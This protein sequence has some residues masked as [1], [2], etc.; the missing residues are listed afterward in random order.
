MNGL[1]KKISDAVRGRIHSARFAAAHPFLRRGMPSATNGMALVVSLTDNV[2]QVKTEGMLAKALQIRG[3]KPVILT[4]RTSKQAQ[5]YFRAFGFADFVFLDDL[6]NEA[7]FDQA[8]ANAIQS[9]ATTFRSFLDVM[10]RGVRIG[11]HVLSTVVRRLRGGSGTFD[12][13]AVKRLIAGL[14]PLSLRTVGATDLLFSRLKPDV[15]CFLEKGYTPYGEIFDA[16]INRNIPCIQYVHSQRSNA[17]VLK[18]YGPQNRTLHPFS[19]SRETWKRVLA[20]P[21]TDDEQKTF[22]AELEKSYAEGTWFNRKF[23][24]EGKKMKSPQEVQVQLKLDPAKKTA[25]IFSHVL[26]DA[27]FFFGSTLFADY[28]EWLVE[29]VR[30]ACANDRV[31]WIIKLHPDYVWKMKMMGDHGD[32]RDI[33]ALQT[34]IGTLPSHVQVVAPDTDISTYSFFAVT[35]YAITVRGTIGIEAPCFGIPVFTAGTGRYSGLGFTEDSATREE[36]LDKM[37]RIQ[38]FPKLSEEKR[39]LALRHAHALFDLRPLD[40]QSF[41]YKRGGALVRDDVDIRVRNV[42]E[43]RSAPD[44]RTYAHWVLDSRDED[45]I[46]LPS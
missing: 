20:Q 45:Y 4:Y 26:W 5:R 22:L 1:F 30:V 10:D 28:E 33:I 19:L 35:D 21:W 44:L 37:A 6:Q 40:F 46:A 7:G 16:A 15:V 29:T 9:S 8:Q 34:N 12:D 13:P 31:N 3:L 17:L 42:E 25:V 27:T 38:E 39:T 14:L 41:S 23:L 36:Y 2:V 18:R 11:N 43:L 32:P 24:L